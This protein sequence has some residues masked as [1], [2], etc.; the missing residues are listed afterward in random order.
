ML[1]QIAQRGHLRRH[2]QVGVL[3]DQEHELVA[4]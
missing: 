1:A 2:D 3:V 4:R